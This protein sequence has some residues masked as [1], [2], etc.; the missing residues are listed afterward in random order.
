MNFFTRPLQFF[1][2]KKLVT[3]LHSCSVPLTLPVACAVV[4][5]GCGSQVTPTSSTST[6]TSTT[7]NAATESIPTSLQIEARAPGAS[8]A[9]E[10]FEDCVALDLATVAVKYVGGEWKIVDGPGGNHWA[11]SFGALKN[12]AYQ[13][14]RVIKAYKFA[15]SC[16]VS[17]PGPKMVYQLTAAGNSAAAASDLIPSE[18]CIPFDNASVEAKWFPAPINSWKIVQGNMWML[19]FGLDQA[20]VYKALRVIKSKK[21]NQQCFVGRPDPSFSYWKIKG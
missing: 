21:F 6:N 1:N 11:F 13:A 5:A 15:N 3:A 18:D 10:S 17:R 16:F 12:E 20:G 19:D 14:L 8:R 9:I 4:I 2:T 7:G